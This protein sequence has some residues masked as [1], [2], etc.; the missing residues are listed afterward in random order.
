L[1]EDQQKKIRPIVEQETAEMGQF[2]GN[3]V[4]SFDDKV[5]GWEKIVRS[6]DKKLTV[7]L[8]ADQVQKLQEMRKEQKEQLKEVKRNRSETMQN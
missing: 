1:S 8:S 2:W 4:L 3:P 5:K 7:F 6:S